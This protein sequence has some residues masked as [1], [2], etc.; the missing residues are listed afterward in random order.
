[1]ATVAQAGRLALHHEHPERLAG[2]IEAAVPVAAWA[3][4]NSRKRASA[5]SSARPI[6]PSAEA[7]SW[8]IS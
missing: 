5:C 3:A 1:M 6:R 7:C 2:C 8:T 4:S